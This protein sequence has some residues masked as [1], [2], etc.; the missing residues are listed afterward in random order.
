MVHILIEC[1][2]NWGKKSRF[3][4]IKLFTL[5]V[6]NVDKVVNDEIF[7]EKVVKYHGA[8]SWFTIKDKIVSERPSKV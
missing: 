3:P 6:S 5:S 4:N 7:S 2:Q 8:Y 1:P